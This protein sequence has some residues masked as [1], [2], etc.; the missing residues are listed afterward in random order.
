MWRVI[1]NNLTLNER[2]EVQWIKLAFISSVSKQINSFCQKHKQN[3]G[4]QSM[5]VRPTEF[6][7][8]FAARYGYLE[9]LKYGL[10]MVWRPPRGAGWVQRSRSANANR[11]LPCALLVRSSRCGLCL[12]PC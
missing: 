6:Q 2:P 1:I 9:C 8:L 3:I 7:R 11:L 10:A 4:I 5:V 12:G